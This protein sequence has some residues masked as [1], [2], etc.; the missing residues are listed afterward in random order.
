MEKNQIPN[1]I[2]QVIDEVNDISALRANVEVFSELT[3][4]RAENERLVQL[5]KNILEILNKQSDFVNTPS[6]K[7][8]IRRMIYDITPELNPY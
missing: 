5:S 8:Y 2:S 7:E 4:L 3:Q 1:A 6:G